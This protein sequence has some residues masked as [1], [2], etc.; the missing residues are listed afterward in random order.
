[1]DVAAEL[2]HKLLPL[3]QE[4][5]RSASVSYP[6]FELSTGSCAVGGNTSY[7]GHQVWLECAFPDAKAEEADHVSV[8]VRAMHI[9][10]EPKL[11]EASVAWGHGQH[12]LLEAELLAQPRALTHESLG[13]LAGRLPE[14]FAVFRSA[15]QARHARSD[16]A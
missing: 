4:E 8:V 7:Q 6:H 16:G 13:E 5:G 11:S 3:L 2:E 15:L 1:M 14:L 9:S 10:T 12:P